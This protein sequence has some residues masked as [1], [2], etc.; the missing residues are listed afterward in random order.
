MSALCG[1]PV[2]EL[3]WLIKS[4]VDVHLNMPPSSLGPIA[5]VSAQTFLDSSRVFLWRL[6]FATISKSDARMLLNSARLWAKVNNAKFAAVPVVEP[7]WSAEMEAAE[8]DELAAAVEA[9]EAAVTAGKPLDFS[10]RNLL[11]VCPVCSETIPGGLKYHMHDKHDYSMEAAEAAEAAAET[12]ISSKKAAEAVATI[13]VTEKAG[14]AR[15]HAAE[16]MK[17]IQA[18]TKKF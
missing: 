10:F 3:Q 18:A 12:I 14:I 7:K 2:A 16:A 11:F 1:L 15:T 8:M 4:G 17:R 9:E 13:K 6:G 5:A